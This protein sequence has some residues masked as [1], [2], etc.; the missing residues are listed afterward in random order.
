M[1][2]T[3]GDGRARIDRTSFADGFMKLARLKE[4]GFLSAQEFNELKAA[5]ISQ[6]KRPSSVSGEMQIV[7]MWPVSDDPVAIPMPIPAVP[8]KTTKKGVILVMAV[9]VGFAAYGY[10]SQHYEKRQKQDREFAADAKRQVE[11]MTEAHLV[12]EASPQQMIDMHNADEAA[13]RAKVQRATVAAAA[14]TVAAAAKKETENGKDRAEAAC[15]DAVQ[16]SLNNPGSAEFLDTGV[17]MM[18][19]KY[20]VTLVLRPKSVFG[21]LIRDTSRCVVLPDSFQ[22]ASVT[23]A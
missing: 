16:A 22:V 18:E 9:I 12:A 7:R 2:A 13:M 6:A 10:S 21:A 19:G 20:K 1:A 15:K 4:H 5:L 8:F 14:V 11:L 23:Q 17:E 3:V